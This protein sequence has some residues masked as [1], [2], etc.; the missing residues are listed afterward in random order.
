MVVR[1]WETGVKL[2]WPHLLCEGIDLVLGLV[3]YEEDDW[4]LFHFPK[5]GKHDEDI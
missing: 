4:E 1:V 3:F 5:E 2:L